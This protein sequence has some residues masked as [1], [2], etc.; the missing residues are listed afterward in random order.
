M[1]TPYVGDGHPMHI[2]DL[3]TGTENNNVGHEDFRKFFK[4]RKTFAKGVLV[5]CPSK[6]FLGEQKGRSKGKIHLKVAG[7]KNQKRLPMHSLFPL[8]PVGAYVRHNITQQWYTISEFDHKWVI[9]RKV[10][11]ATATATAT[12]DA[13]PDGGG[14]TTPDGA[15]E[16]AETSIS[17]KPNKKKKRTQKNTKKK[18]KKNP[19]Q[20]SGMSTNILHSSTHL[21]IGYVYEHFALVYVVI[22][23]HLYCHRWG[24]RNNT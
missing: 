21:L 1:D 4:P 9:L 10:Y 16:A 11:M 6:G 5:A 8:H 22:N 14:E 3:A 23:T 15:A 2:P 7:V 24:W 17:K 12:A 19:R 20:T 13:G 18:K